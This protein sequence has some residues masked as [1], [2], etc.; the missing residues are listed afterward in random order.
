MNNNLPISERFDVEF[1]SS[2]FFRA[3]TQDCGEDQIGV[4][5][6]TIAGFMNAEGGDLY[7]GL[8][9]KGRAVNDVENEYQYLNI[10]P[11]YASSTYTSTEDGY[12]RFIIDWV[13]R[14]FGNYTATMLIRIDFIYKDGIK[15]A[16]VHIGKA[17]SVIWYKGEALYVRGDGANRRLKGDMITMYIMHIDRETWEKNKKKNEN[18]HAA[19]I[20]EI[21]SGLSQPRNKLLVVYPNGNYIYE[22]SSVNTMLEVIRRAGINEVLNLNL[23]GRKGKGKTPYVPFISTR[24]YHDNVPQDSKT[25]KEMDGYYVFVK[26]S[27]GDLMS[28]ILQISDGLG[29]RLHVEIF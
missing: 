7:I 19:K 12:R 1:K 24:Q 20:K 28:K 18:I 29:L 3:G 16:K 26:Y 23:A 11:P 27:I 4:I 5:M 8:D 15:I 22:S 21:K 2:L 14:E 13:A 10:F 9:D 17:F 6:R 25:Q